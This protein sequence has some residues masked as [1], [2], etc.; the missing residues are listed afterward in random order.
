MHACSCSGLFPNLKK[1]IIIKKSPQNH[2]GEW[3]W[4]REIKSQKYDSLRPKEWTTL[5]TLDPPTSL[6]LPTAQCNLICSNLSLTSCRCSSSSC[7]QEPS[8]FRPWL[9]NC[10]AWRLRSDGGGPKQ[11]DALPSYPHTLF[12][13]NSLLSV[14]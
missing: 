4:Y 5:C 9:D 7:C 3:L 10:L 11:T 1:L 6:P 8:S 13:C 14:C 12:P 2:L